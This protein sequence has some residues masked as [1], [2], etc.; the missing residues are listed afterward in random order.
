MDRK[1]HPFVTTPGKHLIKVVSK[2]KTLVE[3]NVFLG[4]QE[5]R[6]IILE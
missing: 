3:E 1:A 5:T 2:G 6:K 4:L